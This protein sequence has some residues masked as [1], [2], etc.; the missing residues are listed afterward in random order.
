[1]T[2]IALFP[3]RA[4]PGRRRRWTWTEFAWWRL[5]SEVVIVS[6]LRFLWGA[7]RQEEI[8]Q[9]RPDPDMGVAG[10]LAARGPTPRGYG[11]PY[12]PDTRPGAAPD[13]PVS[14]PGRRSSCHGDRTARRLPRDGHDAQRR[15]RPARGSAG[16]PRARGR[17]GRPARRRD[18]PAVRRGADAGRQLRRLVELPTVFVNG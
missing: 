10:V 6:A 4:D 11:Q 3:Q 18:P 9:R 13:G 1:M 8:S 5:S 15:P 12:A 14:G 7:A 2:V 16:Q 17:P